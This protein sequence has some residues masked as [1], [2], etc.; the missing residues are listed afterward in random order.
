LF[1]EYFTHL[2]CAA[3][4]SSVTVSQTASSARQLAELAQELENLAG[5][6][7]VM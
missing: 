5:K 6:F 3:E 1:A 7:R 4:E 2:E